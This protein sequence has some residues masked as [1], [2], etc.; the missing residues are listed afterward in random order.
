VAILDVDLARLR[1]LELVLAGRVTLLHSTRL[2]IAEQLLDAPPD[3]PEIGYPFWEGD[4]AAA[5]AGYRTATGVPPGP[6]SGP[7][8]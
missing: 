2:A 6:F 8:A 1:E 5:V 7:L 3:Q 4:L